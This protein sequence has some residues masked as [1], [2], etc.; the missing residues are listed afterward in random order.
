M[1]QDTNEVTPTPDSSRSSTSQ[2]S[3]HLQMSEIV[4][5]P[6]GTVRKVSANQEDS[7]ETE[8]RHKPPCSENPKASALSLQFCWTQLW[9]EGAR[10][11]DAS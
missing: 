6:E 1:H 9:H 3:P 7:S 10:S 4:L 11:S 5:T 8:A 2:N